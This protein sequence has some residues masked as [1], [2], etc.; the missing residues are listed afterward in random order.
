MKNCLSV[1]LSLYGCLFLTIYIYIE[2]ER[3]TDRQTR[4]E[5]KKEDRKL[6]NTY[7]YVEM[8]DCSESGKMVE[9]YGKFNISNS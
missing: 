1:S 5:S 9:V 3:E 6:L 7:I 8:I 2:R 4:I